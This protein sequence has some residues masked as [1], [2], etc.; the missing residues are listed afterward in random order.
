[1]TDS[2]KNSNSPVTGF[3]W[4]ISRR[5]RWFSRLSPCAAGWSPGYTR[6]TLWGRFSPRSRMHAYTNSLRPYP[7]DAD[8]AYVASG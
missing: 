6:R 8:D 4:E 1:M 5:S 2:S 3:G 7:A